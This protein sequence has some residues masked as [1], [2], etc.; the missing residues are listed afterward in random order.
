MSTRS[1]VLCLQG[2]LCCVYKE[3]CVV[4]TREYSVVSTREICALSASS[5]VLCLPGVLCCVYKGVPCCVYKGV[6]LF[7]G[8]VVLSFHIRMCIGIKPVR[9]LSP[10]QYVSYSPG[11]PRLLSAAGMD[12]TTQGGQRL[13]W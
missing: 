10:T 3:Y 13:L 8:S 9:A 1:T 2:V 11:I 5:S 4:S 12:C 7:V 6:L